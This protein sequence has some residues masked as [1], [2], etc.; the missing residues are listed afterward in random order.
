MINFENLRGDEN[1][2]ISLQTI[3]VFI[4]VSRIVNV[5]IITS[6]E[7]LRADHFCTSRIIYIMIISPI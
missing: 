7:K 6:I 5:I 4:F 3:A 2:I 1:M